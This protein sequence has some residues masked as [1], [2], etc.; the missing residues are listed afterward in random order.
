LISGAP[1]ISVLLFGYALSSAQ[2][3]AGFCGI[4]LIRSGAEVILFDAGHAGRRKA[5]LKSLAGQGLSPDDVTTVVVSHAHYDHV[6]NVDLFPR[7]ALW[8]HP[9]ELAEPEAGDLA[10][11]PWTHLLLRGREIRP[12]GDGTE[13]A[14]GVRVLHLP[15]HTAGSVGLLAETGAGTAACTGDALSSA[16]ALRAGVA[17]VVRGDPAVARDSVRRVAALADLV[18]PG[19]DAPFRVCDGRPGDYVGAYPPPFAD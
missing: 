12:A 16:A 14:P 17:T 3:S 19:H 10:R 8:L 5:L 15:G 9:A 1:E 6:Q 13:L 2:G 18:Y 4:Y 11:P 7:A